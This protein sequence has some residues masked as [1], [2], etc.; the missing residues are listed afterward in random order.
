MTSQAPTLWPDLTIREKNVL[1]HLVSIHSGLPQ[2][3]IVKADEDVLVSNDNELG[4]VTRK[5]N[6]QAPTLEE[7]IRIKAFC[8]AS[9]DEIITV[10]SAATSITIRGTTHV[11]DDQ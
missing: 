7:F 10:D 6:V 8:L 2:T 9:P 11:K 5:L 4:S 1:E 3:L